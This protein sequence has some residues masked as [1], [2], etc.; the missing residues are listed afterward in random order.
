MKNIFLGFGI[1]LLSLFN[2]EAYAQEIAIIPYPQQIKL[3]EGYFKL[4][5]QTQIQLA[6]PELKNEAELLAEGI[7][8]LTALKLTTT[9]RK[10]TNQSSQT[11][12]IEIDPK[13]KQN[14]AY[15]LLI[16]SNKISIKGSNK[17]GV[18]Y[19]I[20]SLLQI[21]S[22]TN[23]NNQIQCLSIENDFP[24][25]QWRG[26]H[27]DCA[28]HFFKPDFIKKYI[29]ILAAYKFNYFHWHLTDDQGWRIEILRYPKLTQVGAYRA[30][31]MK[32]HYDEQQY[33]SI[34]FGGYYTQNEIREIVAYAKNRH[35]EIVP[36]ID[37]PGHARAAIA[38]YPELSCTGKQITVGM[39]WGIEKEVLCP[40]DYTFQFIDD[41]FAELA[42][43]FPS[44]YL[45][46]GGDEVIKEEWEAS[47]YCKQIMLSEKINDPLE[48][49]AY[50]MNRIEKIANKYHKKAIGWDEILEKNKDSKA[51]IMSWRGM[52]AGIEA[53]KEKHFVVMTPLDFCYFDHYQG[54][55]ENEPLAIGGL[56]TIEQVYGFKPIPD[57]SSDEI[58]PY[59]LGAQGN[60][61]T[62]YM[63]TPEQVEY[64]AVPRLCALAEVVWTGQSRGDYAHFQKRLQKHQNLLDSKHIHFSKTGFD[65]E[66]EKK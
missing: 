57:N 38:A 7:S 1:V 9:I 36:E 39:K 13:I 16:Q 40:T 24:Q 61:W 52:E 54:P 55:K 62:E 3:N 42:Q 66:T 44:K 17:K 30:G 51:V 50:F 8:D 15:S 34:P 45:H 31:T 60:V 29:D 22:S 19:G 59:I 33:D 56:T 5:N 10:N 32:G 2:S 18:F 58:I 48:L 46:I 41:L 37:M 12:T 27:L 26:M 65:S 4:S 11:I 25:F 35:V 28:R 20:Q 23:N 64:M 14:E 6:K 43:L 21:I 63:K 47:E 49:Q 53:A